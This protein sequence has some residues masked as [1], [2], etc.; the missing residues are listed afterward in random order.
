M[1]LMDA[2]IQ[3]CVGLSVIYGPRRAKLQQP[4]QQPQWPS[5]N[6]V[7]LSARRYLTAESIHG[8]VNHMISDV[9]LYPMKKNARSDR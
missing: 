7:V 2:I 6:V 8:R 5:E 9:G 4:C 1:A 3:C